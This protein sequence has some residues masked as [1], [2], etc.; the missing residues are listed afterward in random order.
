MH[1]VAACL[2][3]MCHL[4]LESMNSLRMT[5]PSAETARDVHSRTYPLMYTLK[6]MNTNQGLGFVIFSVRTSRRSYSLAV[7][8]RQ[9]GRLADLLRVHVPVCVCCTHYLH[10]RVPYI[11]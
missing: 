9:R 5:W 7:F 8:M 4:A 2:Q 3:T 11:F 1:S 10:R 6:T